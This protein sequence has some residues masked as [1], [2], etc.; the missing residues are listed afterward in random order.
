[1]DDM[2]VCFCVLRV[3]CCDILAVVVACVAWVSPLMV[4]T[5]R[6][7][8]WL[9]LLLFLYTQPFLNCTGVGPIKE[10][11]NKPYFHADCFE[12]FKC[13]KA[14]VYGQETAIP[15]LVDNK[16]YH[17]H[18]SVSMWVGVVMVGLTG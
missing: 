14:L 17:Q 18:C 12:C 2:Y 3:L 4:W 15:V 9:L 7:G 5:L 10:L 8:L 1:M 16:V 13:K 11:P 6:C